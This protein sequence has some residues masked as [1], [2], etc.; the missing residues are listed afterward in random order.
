MTAYEHNPLRRDHRQPLFIQV[1][2]VIYVIRKHM[3][4]PHEPQL[5]LSCIHYHQM[6]QV[7]HHIE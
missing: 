4:S 2:L 6:L 3:T 7:L 5:I 1:Y